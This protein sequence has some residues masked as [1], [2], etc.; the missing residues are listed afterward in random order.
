M[1]PGL[2]CS[3][4]RG[5]FPDQDRAGVPCIARRRLNHWTAR[6]AP[7]FLDCISRHMGSQF[8]LPGIK[9]SSPAVE[10]WSL[11]RWTSRE[12]PH[13]SSVDVNSLSCGHPLHTP[14]VIGMAVMTV[15]WVRGN[16]KSPGDVDFDPYQPSPA[17]PAYIPQGRCRRT[18]GG[19]RADGTGEAF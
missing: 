14:F 9:A 8:P 16:R 17:V 5:V 1:V 4:A 18:A 2:S 12:F 6:E 10:A 3:L 15:A 7:C 19:Q 11:N 13:V